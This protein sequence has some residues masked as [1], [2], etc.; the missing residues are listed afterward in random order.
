V[1]TICILLSAAVVHAEG[2]AV[3][4]VPFAI[5]GTAFERHQIKDRLGRVVMYYISRPSAPAPL[6]LMIQG[7]GCVPLMNI[8]PSGTYSTLFDLLPFGSEGQFAVVAVEKP[9]SGV[10][11]G[12]NSGTAESCSAEFNN[13]FTADR[14]LTALQASLD[15]ARRFSWVDKKRTLVLGSSEGAVMAALLA[16]HDNRVTD[17]IS[18]GGSGTTQLFD[19]IVGAY[20]RCFDV[21]PCL[22][23][24][25]H[26][27]RAIA[28]DPSNST[29]FAWGHPYK[30]WSAFFR[31]D[32]SEEL[33][34]SKARVYLAFGT[35]DQATPPLSEEV[36]VAKLMA[37]GRDVTVRRVPNANH[38][39]MQQDNQNFDDL[40]KEFRAALKWFWQIQR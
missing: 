15:D 33:L 20:R 7:S 25:D 29:L 4:T 38:M 26:R 3:E 6:L 10:T 13:D 5:P 27:V 11:S 21:S 36:A 30:R 16:G 37:A 39:L 31:V 9:F 18:I 32:P 12:K 14:W 24:V 8:Q 28:A 35:D 1:C 22:E 17:V 34:R 19:F 23:D 40:D 2:V